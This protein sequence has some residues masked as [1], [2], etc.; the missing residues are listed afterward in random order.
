MES[1]RIHMNGNTTTITH[2]FGI[3][4]FASALV[5]VSPDSATIRAAI[6]RLEDKPSD[7]FA[8]ARRAAHSVTDFLR[9]TPVK[10]SGLSRISLS[11]QYRFLNNERRPIGYVA[12]IDLTVVLSE[13]DQIEVIVSGLVDAGPNEIT[14]TEFHTVKLKELRA[15]ARELAMHAA[16]DKA[17]IYAAAGRVRVGE[18]LHIQDVNPNVLRQESHV[19]GARGPVQQELIDSEP[20]QNP[21]DPSAIQVGAAVLVAYQMSGQRQSARKVRGTAIE[22]G[23]HK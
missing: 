18:I 23:R 20:E 9:K 4:V 22:T 5:R 3:S 10:E 16:R 14:S 2:P 8:E 19:A 13:L 6:T 15:R 12:R 7:A 11:Q 1:A 17:D 21:L